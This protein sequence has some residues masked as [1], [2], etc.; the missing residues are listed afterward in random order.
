MTV[1][2]IALG[3]PIVWLLARLATTQLSAMLFGLTPADPLTIATA[4][5]VLILVAMGAGWVPA[6]RAARIDPIVALRSE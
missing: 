3:L 6:R 4:T 2:G 5:G 1:P